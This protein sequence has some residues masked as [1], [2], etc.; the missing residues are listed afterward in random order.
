MYIQK[1]K[2]DGAISPYFLIFKM[3]TVPNLYNQTI[4]TSCQVKFGMKKLILQ[5]FKF[6]LLP[7]TRVG[8]QN[9]LIIIQ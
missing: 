6:G 4:S 7:H 3:V 1:N 9:M 5:G 2:S 8:L